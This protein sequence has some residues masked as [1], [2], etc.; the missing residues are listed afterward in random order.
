V[1]SFPLPRAGRRCIRNSP[2]RLL[3]RR[4]KHRFRSAI[5]FEETRLSFL[6]GRGDLDAITVESDNPIATLQVYFTSLI[7]ASRKIAR[8]RHGLSAANDPHE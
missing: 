1:S 3:P 8:Q 5:E 4:N 7:D 6:C 2:R